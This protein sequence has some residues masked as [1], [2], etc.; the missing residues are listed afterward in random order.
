[1]LG[2]AFEI[3]TT[4]GLA[5]ITPSRIFQMTGVARTTVYRHWPSPDD[6]VR[7]IVRHATA[8][9]DRHD[10]VGDLRTDLATALRTITFRFANRPVRAL[11]AALIDAD[12]R[13]DPAEAPAA[14]GYVS[15][16]VEPVVE[17]LRD[18]TLR[19]E[20][21]TDLD[22]DRRV[23]ELVGPWFHRHVLLG[24]EIDDDEVDRIVDL[25]AG[26]G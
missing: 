7:D 18:A 19:G 15:G 2:A 4:D 12:R 14:P 16:L 5:A 22:V 21:P 26:S 10:Y 9:H 3:L 11:L 20:L 17:V 24:E 25:V 1:M 8:R 23:S 13:R 6:M